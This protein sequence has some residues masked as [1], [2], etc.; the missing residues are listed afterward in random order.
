MVVRLGHTADVIVPA[1]KVSG[2]RPHE[3]RAAAPCSVS[4]FA[5]TAALRHMPAF[6][7]G[8]SSD[9][10]ARGAERR[11][12]QVV[13]NAAGRTCPCS[14]AVAGATSIRSAHFA[15]ATWLDLESA[16]ERVTGVRWIAR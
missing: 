12:E 3:V 5:C 1:G 9:R 6:I 16:V 7:A 2:L 14:S 13:G 10:L 8:A 15:S 4:K 11:G